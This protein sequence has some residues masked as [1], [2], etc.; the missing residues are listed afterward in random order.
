MGEERLVANEIAGTTRDA[1]DVELVHRGQRYILTDT[2]GIKRKSQSLDELEIQSVLRATQAL[3]R[4]DVAAVLIDAAEPAVEQDARLIG[5]AL[6]MQKPLV[7]LANKI[8]LLPSPDARRAL[9]D[10][11]EERLPFAI[12][13]VPLLFLSAKEGRGMKGFLPL[14][15][16]LGAQANRRIATPEINRFLQEAEDAHPAPRFGGHPVRLYYMAQV[17]IRPLHLSHPRQSPA[18]HHRRLSA[19]FD[20]SDAATVGIADPPAPRLPQAALVPASSGLTSAA[21]SAEIRGLTQGPSAHH[22]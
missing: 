21:P 18:G 17:G 22:T 4:S 19:L 20:Q 5:M 8:D 14:A 13:Y 15:R 7:I 12:G 16:K 9:R 2:A 10:A 1:I 3:Q 6:E 11:I